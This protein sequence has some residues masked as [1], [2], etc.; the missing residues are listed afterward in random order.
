MGPIATLK[1]YL[2]SWTLAAPEKELLQALGIIDASSGGVNVNAESA[3]RQTV[4]YTCV[5]IIAESIASLPLKVYRANPDGVA[6]TARD[7]REYALLT[8]A[9]NE[10]MSAFTWLEMMGTHLSIAG[11]HYAIIN[12]NFGGEIISIIPVPS[13]FG[14]VIRKSEKTGELVYGF[15][16]NGTYAWYGQWDVIHVPAL[17]MDGILGRAPLRAAANS[18][19]IALSAE[20]YGRKFFSDGANPSGFI[21]IPAHNLSEDDL[22]S[23]RNSWNAT[24]SGLQNAHK[25]AILMSGAEWKRIT[26]PP[27][28]AQFLETRKFQ[29]TDICRVFRVPPHMAGDLERATFSN[30]EH[31]DLGFVRHTLRPWLVRIESELN[32]KLFPSDLGTVPEYH[33]EF[34]V[35]GLLRGDVKT[36]ADYYT[37]G[38]QGGWLSGN[39][40]RKFEMMP[41]VKGL[42][43]YETPA[44]MK[45]GSTAIPADGSEGQSTESGNVT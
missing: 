41:P 31:Q 20:E 26:I 18:V 45:G 6:E 25:T 44:F 17:S 40:V 37:K 33:C 19:G 35:D 14:T 1:K 3:M 27:D 36:R 38:R 24:Y 21:S 15:S 22:T 11:N 5:R 23:I 8:H 32:R 43:S 29:V 2:R 39:D 9:P 10:Q 13:P 16:I 42:D 34:V 4:F 28:E 12:R 30:I 7:R